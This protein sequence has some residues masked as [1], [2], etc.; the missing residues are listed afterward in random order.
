ME[1]KLSALPFLLLAISQFILF[2]MLDFR[3]DRI[4]RKMEKGEPMICQKSELEPIKHGRWFLDKSGQFRCS[5]CN[6]VPVN[7]I[8]IDAML[9]YDVPAIKGY[10]K[11]CP[12]CGARMVND[13][14]VD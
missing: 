1:D 14:Q 8:I 2:F 5:N 6:N 9:V 3:L 12:M 13:E 11:Y 7:R 10:M 4:E